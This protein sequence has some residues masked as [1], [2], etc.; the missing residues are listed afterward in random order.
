MAKTVVNKRAY[1]SKHRCLRNYHFLNNKN[2]KTSSLWCVACICP[3]SRYKVLRIF[4]DRG[5][6]LFT[7]FWTDCSF[8]RTRLLNR[9]Y[10]ASASAFTSI[11]VFS[12]CAIVKYVFRV[13]NLVCYVG[14]AFVYPRIGLVVLANK[15]VCNRSFFVFH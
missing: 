14:V 13:S 6:S 12:L 8:S 15:H 9:A 11:S 7:N 10:N 1:V 2:S 3:Y 4:A 5:L